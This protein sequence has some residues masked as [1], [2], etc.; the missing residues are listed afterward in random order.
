MAPDGGGERIDDG[1]P[2]LAIH[3]PI[4][5]EEV[6]NLLDVRPGRRYIDATANGGGHTRAIL[7]TSAPDGRILAFDRDPGLI[8]RMHVTHAQYIETSRLVPVHASFVHMEEVAARHSFLP[9][10]GILFDL[11]LSSYHLDRSGRGFAFARNEP[12]DMRFDSTDV[13]TPPASDWIAEASTD[14][15]VRTFRELGEER[16]ASRIA[17]TIAARRQHSAIATTTDLMEVIERSLPAKVRW[18]AAR[19]AARTFQGL[20]IAVNDELATVRDA[21][22]V[23]WNCLAPNG[24]MAV[25][26][27][28]SLEDRLV[29]H[30]FRER[31]QQGE[32][33]VL[34]KKP[35]SPGDQENARNPRAASAKLRAIV[36]R[37]ASRDD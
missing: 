11:G 34:T 7:E 26:S 36:K 8:E 19:H 18:R 15:L 29:K 4:L 28:H 30:F 20:R 21:L 1:S 33:T 32:G 9:V 22:P 16:F 24:R 35:L 3:E 17:R 37:A 14:E 23:A 2:P 5:V 25:I 12:L 6:L 31:H 27:F 13:D 10:D